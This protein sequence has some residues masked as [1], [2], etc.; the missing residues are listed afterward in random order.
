M[1]QQIQSQ[2]QKEN[3]V[4]ITL[5]Y[6]SLGNLIYQVSGSGNLVADDNYYREYNDFG[7][8][9]KIR[10]G[11]SSNSSVIEEYTYDPNGERIKTYN[12]N[13]STTTYTPFKEFM[14]I[15]NSSGVFNYTYIY[16][17][18]VLIAKVNPDGS[19]SYYH[20]NHLGSTT[21]IT[22]ESGDIVEEISYYPFGEPVENSEEV[23]L[24]E[25]KEY[26]N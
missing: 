22:N 15:R 9:I 26:N 7:Q 2:Q 21:L 18:D 3:D 11:N 23:K 14:Q 4:V 25:N 5:S 16:E 17:G 24:Y 6:D 19:K 20:P 10:K 1:N 8:M 13:T 12:Y